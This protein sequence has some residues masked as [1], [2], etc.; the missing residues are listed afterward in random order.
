MK[1]VNLDAVEKNVST[2]YGDLTGVIQI[3]GHGNITSLYDLCNDYKVLDDNMFIV[4]FELTD[5]E[6][7]DIE[8]DDEVNCNIL[9]LDK[10]TY[11][12]NFDDIENK[13]RKL[14]TLPLRKKRLYVKYGDLGK[15]IKRFNFM[16]LSEM[17]RYASNIQVED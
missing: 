12:N 15:Y 14:D 6:I 10:S 5:S 13:I 9:Y 17:A 11:G 7:R 8:L 16:V 2:Q 4:G 3:D 1:K